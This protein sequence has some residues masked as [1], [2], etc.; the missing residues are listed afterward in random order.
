MSEDF[1]AW[2]CCGA[3]KTESYTGQYLK[4]MLGRQRE[5]AE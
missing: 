1:A 4:P 3:Q 2:M 5:A